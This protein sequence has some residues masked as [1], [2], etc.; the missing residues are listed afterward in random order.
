MG[1]LNNVS[2]QQLYQNVKLAVSA[3]EK[4][5]LLTDL[6]FKIL[7][8]DIHTMEQKINSLEAFKYKSIGIFTGIV[9]IATTF[10]GLIIKFL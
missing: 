7:V 5:D 3:K 10:V 9:F 4:V 2:R 1:E 6:I 8:N